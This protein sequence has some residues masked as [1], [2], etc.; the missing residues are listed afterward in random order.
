[1]SKPQ[2]GF[3]WYFFARSHRLREHP[4]N[5]AWLFDPETM[6][7]YINNPAFV[8]A[9]QDIID[10][11]PYEPADQVNADLNLT[12]FEEF[13]AGI[14]SMVHWWGDVGSFVYRRPVGC[15]GQG[16]V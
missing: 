5:K 16:D 15:S 1:M 13:L 2:D 11:L 7:P 9:A 14:G 3:D 12:G 4:Q 6:K 8:R 10:A